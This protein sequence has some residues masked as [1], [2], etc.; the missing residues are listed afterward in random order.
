M[1]LVAMDEVSVMLFREAA[2]DAGERMKSA[3]RAGL[4]R[5]LAV[6][7]LGCESSDGVGEAGPGGVVHGVVS[8]QRWSAIDSS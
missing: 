5:A 4:G 3:F 6:V 1:A 8:G 2:G 7:E